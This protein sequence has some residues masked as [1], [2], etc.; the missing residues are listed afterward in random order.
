M[1]RAILWLLVLTILAGA[2][3]GIRAIY[4]SD[5][6][7][8]RR[9]IR[10]L[11]VDVSFKAGTGNIAKAAKFNRITGRLTDDF[12]ISVEQVV[13]K[14]PEMQGQSEIRAAIQFILTQFKWCDVTVHDVVV[15]PVAAGE[16]EARA[17]MTISV[18]TSEPGAEITA[19]EFDVKLRKNQEGKWQLSRVSAVPT[20]KR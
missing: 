18:A 17:A 3:L 7:R 10:G 14:A 1:K 16:R 4:F 2:L 13:P 19:Q 11:L 9:T 20:L 15:K 5:E 8:V 6:A 12:T